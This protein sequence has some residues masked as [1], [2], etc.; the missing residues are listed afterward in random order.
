MLDIKKF[1]PEITELCQRL[2]IRRLDVFGSATSE[3]F[4]ADSDVN[5]LVQFE[6]DGDGLFDRY[7][8]PQ[9]GFEAIF[10]RPVDMVVEDS[11][12]NPYFRASVDRSRRTVYAG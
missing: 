11:L 1:K 6:L 3:A 9:E 4:G 12:K 7:F 10:G 8:D 2:T 5:V